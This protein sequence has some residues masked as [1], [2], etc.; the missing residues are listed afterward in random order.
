M[1]VLQISYNLEASTYLAQKFQL[2]VFLLL[3]WQ[4]GA[5]KEKIERDGIIL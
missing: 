4:I 1:G 3:M 5:K 2:F